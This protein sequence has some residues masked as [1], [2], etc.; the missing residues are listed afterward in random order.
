MASY[1]IPHRLKTSVVFKKV[2]TLTYA[3]HIYLYINSTNKI[4]IANQQLQQFQ[5]F[6]RPGLT[7]LNQNKKFYSL[8]N[9]IWLIG[10]SFST[11]RQSS[12]SPSLFSFHSIAS[13]SCSLFSLSSRI[14]SNMSMELRAVPQPSCSNILGLQQG[15][16]STF[17]F[18]SRFLQKLLCRHRLIFRSRSVRNTSL[19]SA[20]VT[21]GAPA[22]R[23]TADGN[24]VSVR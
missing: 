12:F 7:K 14:F 4:F 11:Q 15:R 8:N 5:Q 19:F 3:L 17:T 13:C 20:S 6:S 21:Q 2:N 9:Q 10:I 1:Y 16:R 23:F 24:S 18:C 22:T